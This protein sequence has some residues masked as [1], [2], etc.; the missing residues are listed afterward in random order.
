MDVFQKVHRRN[1][2]MYKA[3]GI[4]RGTQGNIYK[5]IVDGCTAAVKDIENKSF[6]YR[7]LIGRWLLSREI[8]IYQRLQGVPGIPRLYGK[9]DRDGFIFEYVE[10]VP[11]SEYAKDAPLPPQFFDALSDLVRKIHNRGVVHSDLKHKKNILVTG[12]D[13]PYLVDFGASWTIASRWNLPKRWVYNQFQ[14]IDLNA[15]SKIRSRYTH[16][17]PGSLDHQNLVR[18]NFMEQCSTLYQWIYRFF[19]SKHKWKRRRKR[20]TAASGK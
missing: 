3:D 11:L 1:L 16:G 19:S 15:V 10:G 18:R 7:L 9:M 14:Q 17:E 6:L 8:R 4:G 13:Q 5:V 2:E 20:P 12:N